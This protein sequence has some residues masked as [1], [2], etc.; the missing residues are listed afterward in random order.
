MPEAKKSSRPPGNSSE[1]ALNKIDA[2]E[3]KINCMAKAKRNTAIATYAGLIIIII[4][5]VLFIFNIVSYVRNYDTV[6]LAA[7]LNSNA[8]ELVQSEEMQEILQEIRDKF[9]PALKVALIQK[10]QK[11]TPLFRQSAQELTE[12][13]KNYLEFQIKPKLADSLTKELASSEAQLLTTYSKSKPSLEKINQIVLK[14]HQFLFENVTKSV[15]FKLDKA[16]NT[17]TGL[18]N[19]FQTMYSSMEDTP[20]LK[21][22]TPEMTG[23]VENLLIET[24]LELII[25]QLNPQKGNM[26]AFANGGAE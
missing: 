20:L 23:E 11:D 18:N 6:E 13:L 7:A 24:M 15:D 26:P 10:M 14:S 5:I 16:L 22:L 19:S 4:F 1:I 12:D 3:K 2:L 9:V 17:L 8:I 21:G 25:Y